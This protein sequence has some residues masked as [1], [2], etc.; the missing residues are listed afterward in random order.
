MLP[1][2]HHEFLTKNWT[3]GG[4]D[5]WFDRAG[6]VCGVAERSGRPRTARTVTN[7]TTV[8]DMLLSQEDTPHT[9]H[10]VRQIPQEAGN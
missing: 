8:E 5:Y 1:V 2:F 10:T 9:H 3:Q 4:L 6:S 7:I